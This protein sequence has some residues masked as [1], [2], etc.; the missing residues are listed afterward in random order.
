M[1]VVHGF[2][3][4]R[5]A[6]VG[7][8]LEHAD[9]AS[10]LLPRPFDLSVAR[11]KPARQVNNYGSRGATEAAVVFLEELWLEMGVALRHLDALVAKD[12]LQS[13]DVAAC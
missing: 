10:Q 2:I 1:L 4:S 13:E 12:L 9:R 6:L 5:W 8:R 3:F 7:K 11:V